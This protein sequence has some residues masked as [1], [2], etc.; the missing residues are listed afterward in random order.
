MAQ[1]IVDFDLFFQ[2]YYNKFRL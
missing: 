2:L 1:K